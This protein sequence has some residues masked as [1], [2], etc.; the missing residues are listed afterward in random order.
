MYSRNSYILI[1][2]DNQMFA[3]QNQ[4]P[5][6]IDSMSGSMEEWYNAIDDAVKKSEV[7]PGNYEYTVA[8]SYGNVGP[9]PEGSSTYFDVACDRFKVV[10]L[11]NSFITIEQDVEIEVPKHSDVSVQEYYIGYKYAGDVID[12]YRIY[13]NTDLIQTQNHARYEWFMMYNSISDEAK[14][15]SDLYATLDKIREKNPFV[16]GVYVNL[17]NIT[18]SK[19]TIS[20]HLK[21]RIPVSAFLTLFN[22]R[23]FPNWSGKLS[24]EIYPS[25]KNLCI[26]PV[27]PQKYLLSEKLQEKIAAGPGTVELGFKNIN[28]PM[29]NNLK[30]ASFGQQTESWTI[31]TQ[32]FKCNG[33]NC[34]ADKC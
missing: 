17:K 9:I 18:D 24:I 34:K 21:V 30:V 33:T 16:P 6:V 13:S 29:K 26:V 28:Q 7:I 3:P 11:D 20:V 1:F 27:V 2:F 19:K 10:S 22:L 25:Y 32:T 15:N 31:A 12:Q 5:N 4:Q 23:F 8:T 14:R